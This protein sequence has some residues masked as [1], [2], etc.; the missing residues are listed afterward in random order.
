[1]VGS[2]VGVVV[3]VVVVGV[4]VGVVVLDTGM[5]YTVAI[6]R[7]AQI[8]GDGR[9]KKTRDVRNTT[10]HERHDIQHSTAHVIYLGPTLHTKSVGFRG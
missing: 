2:T 1:M 5:E 6:H 9:K 8:V 10:R 3:C 4:V 7:D